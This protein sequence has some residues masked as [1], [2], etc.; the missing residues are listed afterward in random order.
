MTKKTSA[1][2]AA[3]NAKIHA[4]FAI[5]GNVGERIDR[6]HAVLDGYVF[7]TDFCS[8]NWIRKSGLLKRLA[9][10]LAGADCAFIIF[11]RNEAWIS[12]M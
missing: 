1:F 10:G 5:L 3:L 6:G 4:A 8:C 11:R 2:G 12:T 7:C 9:C